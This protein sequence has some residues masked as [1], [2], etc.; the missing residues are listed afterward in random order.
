MRR[1]ALAGFGVLMACSSG[2][3]P[4]NP[5]IDG[6]GDD[7]STGSDSAGADG[8]VVDGGGKDATTD[9]GKDA[10]S[11]GGDAGTD[12][13]TDATTDSIAVDVTPIDT[14]PE[15]WPSDAPTFDALAPTVCATDWPWTVT[16]VAV[17]YP[18]A[19]GGELLA[20]VTW[21]EQTMAWTT[22]DG[23]TV[24][25]HYAD[26]AG[27]DDAF[28][29]DRTLPTSLGPFVAEKVALSADG[30]RMIFTSADHL[31]IT[32]ISR[33]TRAD[34]F[35]PA[36][37]TS[38]PFGRLMASEGSDPHAV[39][40]LVL[41]RDERTLI[42]T[43]LGITSGAS[44]RMSTHLGDGTWDAPRTIDAASLRMVGTLRRRPSGLSADGRTLFYFDENSRGPK[45]AVRALG[46]ADFTAFYDINPIGFR[47]MPT[48][49][50]DR[51]YMS[52]EAD[53]DAA[54]PPLTIIH[55]P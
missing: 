21:D 45:I 25:V 3:H 18:H 9:A 23:G 55:A 17:T 29:S 15:V 11:D 26:R 4:A 40:D 34:A 43:D 52:V 10:T 13:T 47:P 35:D 32:Q 1:L 50:C 14:G 33:P 41:S 54:T 24:V 12:A 27:R 19:A 37:A 30:L 53:V 8:T 5:S 28:G 7:T 49:T 20:A 16:P 6:G 39:A 51:L 38:A 48:E 46:S 36:T 22:A 44:I 31:T 42:F 2:D